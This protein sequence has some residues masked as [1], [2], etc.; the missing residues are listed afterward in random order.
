[1][2]ARLL[3]PILSFGAWSASAQLPAS[4]TLSDADLPRFHAEIAR[5]ERL[6]ETAPDK[7][8][9]TYEIARTWASAKQW[10][11]TIEWLRNVAERN[12]GIDPSRDP[13]FTELRGTREF[14]DILVA[15]LRA[16]PP[17]S[18]STA[19]F[20]VNEGDLVPE[21]MAYDPKRERFYFG[22]M[23][24]GKVVR[25]TPAGSCTPFA[26][27]LGSVLGLKVFADGLWFLS[28]SDKEAALIH[29]DLASGRLVRRY[30]VKGSGHEFNDLAI[31][32]GGDVFVTD[33]RAGAVWRLASGETELHRLQGQFE[34]ANGITL[35]PDGG[36]LYVSTFPEGIAVVDLKTGEAAPIARPSTLCLATIDGLYYYR[37]ALVA[38]QNAFVSPRVVRLNLT[39]D[40]RGIADFDILERRNPLFDGVTTGVIVG[41]DLYYM[42][43]IQDEKKTGFVPVTIL[44]VRL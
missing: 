41:G 23:K 22:S 8:T 34:F 40:H 38:I 9:V 13:V 31:A 25:C 42:A 36:L 32:S 21:S 44:K 19:V 4:G 16:T 15:V 24:K 1:V 39:E 10:P 12:S 11:E 35:S 43:N 37:G 29:Y 3:V 18:H 20:S 17:V 33:T 26:V 30:A 27:G 28:N 5:L 7:D 14:D 6:L 2:T